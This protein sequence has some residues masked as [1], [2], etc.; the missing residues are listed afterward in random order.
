M[1]SA[2]GST[3][4]DGRPVP[5]WENWQQGLAVIRYEEGDHPF[6]MESVFIDTMAGHRAAYGGQVYEPRA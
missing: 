6:S 3:G 2:K 1:P 4:L 5:S